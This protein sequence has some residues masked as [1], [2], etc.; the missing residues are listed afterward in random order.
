MLSLTVYSGE[1]QNNA[2]W[3]TFRQ[4]ILWFSVAYLNMSEY[5]N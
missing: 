1:F 3:D 5:Y 2:L 4:A